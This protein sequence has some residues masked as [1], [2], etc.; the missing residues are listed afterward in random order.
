MLSERSHTRVFLR[1]ECEVRQ[2]AVLSVLCT[3]PASPS[4]AGDCT[5]TS[6]LW[7]KETQRHRTIVP[8]SETE[9]IGL[10]EQIVSDQRQILTDVF[11]G[12]D[13][14]T[15]PQL[16]CLCEYQPVLPDSFYYD[17]RYIS[18][19]GGTRVL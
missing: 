5:Y 1:S 8:L 18:R 3:D 2:F 14:T 19:P 7:N 12:T 17:P 15:I 10:L 11:N 6:T 13:V 16:W 4:G 9:N